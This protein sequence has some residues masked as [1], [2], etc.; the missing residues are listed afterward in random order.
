MLPWSDTMEH[1]TSPVHPLLSYSWQFTPPSRLIVCMLVCLS[2]CLIVWFSLSLCMSGM[3]PWL[4]NKRTYISAF[5][6]IAGL[7]STAVGLWSAIGMMSS[8]CP[9]VRLS[10]CDE[11][12]CSTQGRCWR[13]KLSHRVPWTT[14][15]IHFLRHICCWMHRSSRTYSEKNSVLH[16]NR[17]IV[18]WVS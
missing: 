3:L 11:V 9:S 6:L 8:V 16:I 14:L 17:P 15:S 18:C 1:R 4:A 10:V 13:W 5:W 12:Y 7:L 2:V